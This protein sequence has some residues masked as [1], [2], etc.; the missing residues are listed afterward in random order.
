MYVCICNPFT[1]TDVRNYLQGIGEKKARVMDV[2]RSCSGEP[3][4]NCGSCA[5]ELRGMVDKHNNTL[6]IDAISKDMEKVSQKT[7]ENV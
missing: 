2:Y 6:T 1:D 5:C 7:K 4:M 3:K